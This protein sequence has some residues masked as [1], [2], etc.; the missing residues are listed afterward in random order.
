VAVV[1]VELQ[2]LE[3]KVVVELAVN[4]PRQW[5]LFPR[6]IHTRSLLAQAEPLELL[7]VQMG[8]PEAIPPSIQLRR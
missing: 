2:R 5:L 4:L 8:V 6:E 7:L 1:V 3:I